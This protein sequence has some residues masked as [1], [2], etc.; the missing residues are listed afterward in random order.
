MTGNISFKEFKEIELLLLK[1]DQFIF[2]E[3]K[4]EFIDL[5][6]SLNLIEYSDGLLKVKG[7]LENSTLQLRI[8]L[9]RDSHLANLIIWRS[10][11]Q[12][13][14]SGLKDTLNHLRQK[15]W[16]TRGRRTVKGVIKGCV[17]CLKQNSRPFRSLPTVPLPHYRINID[18]PFSC[19]CIDYLGPLY[20]KNIFKNDPNELSKVYTGLYT[21]AS[22][23]AVYLDLVPDASSRSFVNSLKR[24]IARHGT[25]KLF[26]SDNACSFIGPEVQDYISH[27]N[28]GWNFILDLSPWW[29]GFWECLVQMVKR[30]MRK[31]LQ[32]N[33]LTY[34]EFQT[35]VIEIEGILNTRPLCYIYD[36]S[37]DTVITPLHL[38]FGRNLLTEISADDAKNN[39]S[40]RLRHLQ[41]LSQR[42]W[43][44]WSSEYLTEL[45]ERHINCYKETV[46]TI[47]NGEIVLIKE[48]NLPRS[49]W[50]IVESRKTLYGRRQPCK[51]MFTKSC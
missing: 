12:R 24:F 16:V 39:Y 13:F 19:T 44:K 25:P 46:R 23:R 6:N 30:S 32:K 8:L 11:V 28:I 7:R 17:I 48:D 33:K 34:K 2:K 31:V 51:R 14:H 41:G 38:I 27:A 43:N 22:T 40:K 4:Y 49:R 47:K 18:F 5:L 1:E 45:R 3:R 50:R 42:F 37:P 21:C 36:D 35:V 10:H 26:I 20:V 9:N 15:C 29:G